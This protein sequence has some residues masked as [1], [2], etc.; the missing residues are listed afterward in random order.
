METT[1]KYSG[2]AVLLGLATAVWSQAAEAQIDE[3]QARATP[4]SGYWWPSAKGELLTPLGKYDQL[5][6]ASAAQWERQHNPPGPT[7]PG[8]HGYC[9]A[10]ASSSVLEKEP[11][12]QHTATGP[13][14]APVTLGVG[15]QKGLLAA[16]H[17]QDATNSYGDR[18]GDGQGSEDYN[19][20]SPDELWRLLRLYVKQQGL[21]LILDTEPG[22]QV[23]NYPVYAYR[24]EYRPQGAAGDY[25]GQLMLLMSDDSVPP[26]Y[27]GVKP[28]YEVHTFTM[29]MANGA[30]VPGSARWVGQSVQHHPDFAWYPY[31]VL[32]Q[33]PQIQ[34]AQVKQM[35]ATGS[36]DGAGGGPTPPQPGGQPPLPPGGPSA[37]PNPPPGPQPQPTQ[38]QPTQPPPTQPPPT[39]PPPTQPPPTQPQP[40]QPPPTQPPPNPLPG[41]PTPPQPGGTG[42]PGRAHPGQILIDPIELAALIA[43]KTSAFS[44]D[45]TVDRFDG[46]HYTQDDVV[47]VSGSSERPGHLYLL[48]VNSQG[49]V[50][51]LYPL[52]SEDNRVPAHKE[53]VIPRPGVG[54]A[55]LYQPP[56]VTRIKALVA[57]QPL[58]L[59]GLGSQAPGQLPKGVK[60][61]RIWQ[62]FEWPPS[63]QKL[64]EGL[65]MR[66]QKQQPLGLEPTPFGKPQR[67]LG[68]FAQDE[69][70]FYVGPGQGGKPEFGQPQPPAGPR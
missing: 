26:D 13:Q 65:L 15:D 22:E 12:Q 44:L 69:V 63:Q 64:V 41:G 17:S 20:I 3:G 29:R 57:A 70:A 52:P 32:S 21:P 55:M 1:M 58:M 61:G 46:G 8:W 36:A 23:W 9:H 19:D 47:I 33:N 48:L 14:G 7:V 40:T 39:Q 35:I 16:S 4:W 34:Y 60:G 38:P 5:T 6:G 56:G 27:V 37:P 2:I 42:L 18:Y 10:W 54:Y 66:Y 49:Q 50:G 53:F 68:E 67:L 51:L 31:V 25:Y 24:I 62:T 43:D 59:S 11:A 28:R 30:T 45:V